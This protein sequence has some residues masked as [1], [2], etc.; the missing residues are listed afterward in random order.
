[1]VVRGSN[2]YLSSVA[3]FRITW[4]EINWLG[5][6]VDHS[7]T[8]SQDDP[9]GCVPAWMRACLAMLSHYP[10]GK[11]SFPLQGTFA[12]PLPDSIKHLSECPSIG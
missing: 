1:M 6:I 8:T 4:L 11:A 12:L 10:Y 9:L 5:P 3:L 7:E 2:R